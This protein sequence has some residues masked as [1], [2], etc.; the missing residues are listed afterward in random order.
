M[1]LFLPYF[2]EFEDEKETLDQ[3]EVAFSGTKAL[4][5]PESEKKTCWK[6]GQSIKEKLWNFLENPSSSLAAKV[7]IQRCF[8]SGN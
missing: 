3:L 2:R 1:K 7:F 4:K 6:K 5:V 8:I